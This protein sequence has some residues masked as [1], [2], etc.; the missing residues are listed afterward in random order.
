MSHSEGDALYHS[1]QVFRSCEDRLPYDE[2]LLT[3][4]CCT[5]SERLSIVAIIML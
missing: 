2:E 1:L 3:P 4:R 5:M